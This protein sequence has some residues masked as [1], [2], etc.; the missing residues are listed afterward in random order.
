MTG[1]FTRLSVSLTAAACMVLHLVLGCCV[2]HVHAERVHA[3]R[4]AA[5]YTPEAVLSGCCH[6]H[7]EPSQNGSD[8]D[9]H[10]PADWCDEI[11]QL[12]A[13]VPSFDS[14]VVRI[15]KSD[16]KF[17]CIELAVIQQRTALLGMTQRSSRA[18]DRPAALPVRAYLSCSALLL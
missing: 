13:T 3:E 6:Q 2:H 7:C 18:L 10:V 12:V 5:A 16:S 4:R 17:R 15:A 1:L 11:C 8:G 9:N 14:D